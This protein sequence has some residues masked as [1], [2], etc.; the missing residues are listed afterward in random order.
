MLKIPVSLGDFKVKQ[1]GFLG[2]VVLEDYPLEKG[3]F[4]D[5]MS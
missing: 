4:H 1:S 3:E 2:T 5:L